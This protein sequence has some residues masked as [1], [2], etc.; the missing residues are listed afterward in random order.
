MHHNLRLLER[1]LDRVLGPENLG[2][3]L[4]SP[5][6]CLHKEKVDDQHFEDVP[7][8]EQEI[9]LPPRVREGNSGDEGVVEGGDVDEEL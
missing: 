3:F 1:R 6:A 8:Y 2:Q 4:Q 7:E 9:V 5:L